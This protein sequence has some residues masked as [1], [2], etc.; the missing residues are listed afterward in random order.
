MNE[1]HARGAG[2]DLAQDVRREHDGVLAAELAHEL[3]HLADLVGVE[4]RRG[5][6]EDDDGRPRDDRVRE[7]DALPVALREVPDALVG[8]V[9]DRGPG[10][11]PRRCR[12]PRTA[13]GTRLS[14][15]RKRRYST[16]RIS[17]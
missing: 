1:Q 2:L 13:R 16:T 10:S 12:P 11:S 5:L 17:G 4:P 14:S 9:E 3:A 8:D 6:V 15:A 7:P